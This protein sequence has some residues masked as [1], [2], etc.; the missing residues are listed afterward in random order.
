[1][2]GILTRIPS[3]ERRML[4]SIC[5]ISTTGTWRSLLRVLWY[6]SKLTQVFDMKL[7]LSTGCC[8]YILNTSHF[9]SYT[10]NRINE[11]KQGGKRMAVS[12]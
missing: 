9:E 12:A 7:R 5:A 10:M 4:D 1:M 6:E 11:R 2:V 8:G 3:S